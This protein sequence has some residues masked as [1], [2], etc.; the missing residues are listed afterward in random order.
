[1][2][3]EKMA[4]GFPVAYPGLNAGKLMQRRKNITTEL[5]QIKFSGQKSPIVTVSKS[6]IFEAPA[7]S[8]RIG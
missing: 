6:L 3:I 5:S 2:P 8:L 1:M 4:E 7:P